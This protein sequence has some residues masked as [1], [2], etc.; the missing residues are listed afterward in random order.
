[1]TFDVNSPSSPITSSVE[2]CEVEMGYEG[3]KY[4]LR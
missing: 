1:M 3:I 2:N 4:I